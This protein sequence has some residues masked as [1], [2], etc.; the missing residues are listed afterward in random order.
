MKDKREQ[1]RLR[2]SRRRRRVRADQLDDR[3]A[4]EAAKMP[5]AWQAEFLA[6]VSKERERARKAEAEVETTAL[7]FPEGPVRDLYRKRNYR[8]TYVSI[9]TLRREYVKRKVKLVKI[10]LAGHAELLSG[11]A[12]NDDDMYDD[13]ALHPEEVA[14]ILNGASLQDVAEYLGEG[15]ANFRATLQTALAVVMASFN[16]GR[17]LI[18][19]AQAI[20]LFR[21]LQKRE[22]TVENLARA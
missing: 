9:P 4:I 21:V 22:E 10:E 18:G 12:K 16:A 6:Y 11:D 3:A 19:F 5:L 17:T 15:D 20:E 8:N 13:D 2:Q 7:M 1:A 14:E